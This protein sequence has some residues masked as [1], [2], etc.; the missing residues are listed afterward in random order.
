[1]ISTL[2]KYVKVGFMTHDRYLKN[3]SSALVVWS[4]LYC[5]RP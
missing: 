4:I 2:N 5:V 1:M 3:M